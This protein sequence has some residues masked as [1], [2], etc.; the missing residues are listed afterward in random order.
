[1]PET[2]FEKNSYQ[3]IEHTGV[4]SFFIFGN[5]KDKDNDVVDFHEWTGPYRYLEG[6]LYYFLTTIAEE[7][8]NKISAS[9]G[10]ELSLQPQAQEKMH[11]I[12]RGKVDDNNVQ[13][14]DVEEIAKKI[15]KETK[16]HIIPFPQALKQDEFIET[17]A[18]DNDE[19]KNAEDNEK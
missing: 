11:M 13:M 1:M 3:E 12:K 2:E 10:P 15:E 7:R 4:K 9:K 6:S 17:P 8:R 19:S 18:E 16:Q 5:K 14:V